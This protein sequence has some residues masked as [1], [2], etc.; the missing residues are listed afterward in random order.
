MTKQELHQA[1]LETTFRVLKSNTFDDN[2]DLHINQYNKEIWKVAPH[3]K[4]WAFITAFNPSPITFSLE[5]NLIR[6]NELANDLNLLNLSY[7]PAIGI[8]KDEKWSEES[9]FIE[10]ISQENAFELAKK[11][12]QLAFVFGK[13]NQIAQLIYCE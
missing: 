2:I 6:N 5:E 11:Y 13:S 7:H 4:T 10:N 3:I 8:S 12:G 1:F 9:F